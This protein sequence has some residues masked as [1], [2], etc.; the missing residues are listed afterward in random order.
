MNI[1]PLYYEGKKF[2]LDEYDPLIHGDPD[3]IWLERLDE[4]GEPTEDYIEVDDELFQLLSENNQIEGEEGE[5]MG[6]NWN[7]IWWQEDADNQITPAF[8]TYEPHELI[9][10]EAE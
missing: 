3:E 2:R 5:D 4:S 9:L 6:K 8:R 7:R 1:I 10:L